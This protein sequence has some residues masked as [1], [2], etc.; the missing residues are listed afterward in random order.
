MRLIEWKRFNNKGALICVAQVRL[1]SGLILREVKLLKSASGYFV[2]AGSRPILKDGQPVKN[3]A[4][5]VQ[6]E[7]LVA[8]VDRE[9]ADRFGEA[10][11]EL[12]RAEH[13][14]DLD[15]GAP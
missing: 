12:I 8:F 7:R 13:P 14:G 2:D 6:H 11:I 5:Y 15:G 1:G 9:T 3:H 10:V 4:G